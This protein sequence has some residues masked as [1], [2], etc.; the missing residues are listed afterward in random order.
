MSPF[1]F[2]TSTRLLRAGLTA[3][4]LALASL[5]CAAPAL[6]DPP[7]RVGRLAELQ[8]TVWFYSPD[9]GDWIAAVR[10]R[11][12]TSG[13]RLATDAGAR[14]EVRI[15]SS[16]LRLDASSELEVLRLDDEEV[17]VQ[18]HSGSAALRLVTP[19]AAREFALVTGEGRFL[20]L[21]P[22]SYRIDRADAT[23][24]ATA[25]RGSLRYE[26][27]GQAITLDNGQRADF[28]IEAGSARYNLTAPDRDAFADWVASSEREDERTP[29]PSYVS[30]EMTGAEDLGR[31]GNWQESPEYGAL[32]VPSVVVAGWAPYRYGHWGFVQPWGWT[33]IDDAP[34]GFAPF[35]YGR[36]VQFR[37]Q[38]GWSPG[39]Y[40]ARPVYAPALVAWVGGP[41]FSVSVSVGSQPSVGWFPLGP[42]EVF[43]PGYRVSP[44]Y[45]RNVNVTQVTNITN[46][47]NIINQPN[48]VVNRTH[49]INRGVANAVTVVPTSVLTRRQP[50]APVALRIA[51]AQALREVTRQPLVQAAPVAAPAPRTAGRAA[52]PSPLAEARVRGPRERTALQPPEPPRDREQ[53]TPG[54]RD[55]LPAGV[56]PGR[57]GALPKIAV[58]PPPAA[59]VPIPQIGRGERAPAPVAND[60]GVR[61]ERD[62][63]N[64][65]DGRS[66]PSERAPG[67]PRA[68][69][70]VPQVL[71][72][73][74]SRAAQPARAAPPQPRAA[75]PEQALPPPRRQGAPDGAGRGERHVAPPAAVMPPRPAPV[76]PPRPAIVAEPQPP[77]AVRAPQA[78]PAPRAQPAAPRAERGG[79]PQE[80]RVGPARDRDDGPPQRGSAN[81]MQP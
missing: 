39:R 30:P 40:V 11:P 15:G 46:V 12:V 29:V 18:L 75:R 55:N 25:W 23:S 1:P 17:H 28:W 36:W 22:G 21:E 14:A 5:L 50:V 65:R 79:A 7:G 10:N 69:P 59:A 76:A 20:P 52:P 41:R 43:V 24:T 54:R 13:D 74:N 73:P 57:G 70:P 42:R 63:R 8:G 71:A 45:V 51:D 19:N 6:A 67:G 81:R 58:P 44:G 78:V 61:N 56:T 53:A 64:E 68:A 62:A 31:Y 26:G 3:A 60:R 77:A 33:W 27:N 47:T 48:T 66:T 72:P 38:W 80:R 9:N 2:V 34:W 32:W 4:L 37:G 35:H 49:Y 16:T